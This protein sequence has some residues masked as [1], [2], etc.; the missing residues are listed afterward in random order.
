[1]K[2]NIRIV[3]QALTLLVVAFFVVGCADQDEVDT[4]GVALQVEF[5]NAP[6]RVGVNDADTFAIPQID[7]ENLQVNTAAASSNLMNVALDLYE[8][9]FT[10][11][12]G[13]SRTPPPYVFRLSGVVPINGTL[14]LQN[15]PVMSVDQ[16]RNRRYRI[17]CSRT[18]A[19]TRR[20]ARR[21]S[22]ST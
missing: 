6:F 16:L 9:T 5:I 22:R 7:I 8:V 21:R 12:D 3:C 11:A 15:F 17:S 4:G 1:M 13:G 2:P 18:A 20:P 14:T 19:S 10:R